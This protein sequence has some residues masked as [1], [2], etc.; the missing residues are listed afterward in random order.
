MTTT[1]VD[2]IFEMKIDGTWVDITA[3]I[4]LNS[5]DSGGGINIERGIPN[6]GNQ[7]EPTQLDFVLNNRH[8]DY[9]P[10]N[11][12]SV[13]YGKLGRNQPVRVGLSRRRDEFDR[14][15]ADSWG[16]L[17]DRVTPELETV[18][19]ERWNI[20]GTSSAFD[21]TP[22]AGTIQAATG[23]RGATFGTYGDVEILAR[24]KVSN[25]TSEFGVVM[26][27]KSTIESTDPGDFES[28]LGSWLPFG[29]TSTLVV[30]TA[31]FH[32]GAHSALLTVAG[33]PAQAYSRPDGVPVIPGRSYRTRIWVRCSATRN[34]QPVID[35]LDSG[36]GYISSTVDNIAVTADTWTVMEVTGNAPDNAAF[37]QYG[38]TLDS[39]PANGTLLF[40]DDLELLDL[41]DIEYFT[42]YITP[43]TPDLLRLGKVTGGVAEA[44]SLSQ[45][46]NVVADTFYWFKAQMS[47][48]RRRVKFWA[49]GDD[50][51]RLWNWRTYETAAA[52][53]DQT[54]Q[55][56][57]EVG[58]FCKDGTALVTFSEV[59]INQWRAHAEIQQLPQRWDLSRQDR[60]VPVAARGILQ[61]LGQGRKSLDSAVTLHLQEYTTSRMWI[62]LETIDSGSTTA[63]NRVAGGTDALVRGLTAATPEQ[64]GTLALP[65]VSGYVT[66]DDENSFLIARARPGAAA[67]V[68]SILVFWKL[69]S[70]PASDV[71]LYQVESSGTGRR[72][73]VYL[74]TDLNMRIEVRSDINVLLDQAFGLSYFGTEHPQGCWLAA[75]LYILQNGGNVDYAWNYH[76]PGGAN[77]YTANGSFAGTAGIFREIRFNSTAAIVTAGNLSITQIF[78]YPGDLP[79]VTADFA[80]AAYAYIGEEAVTRYLRLTLNAGIKSTTTGFTGDS[81]PMGAQV[82]AKLLDNLQ[83]CAEIDDSILMEERDDD[84]LN[85]RTR[86]S[87]WNQ[88]PLELDIDAGHL[89][90][91]LDPT[92]DDQRT[93]NDITVKRVNGSFATSVQTEGPLNVNAPEDDPDGVGTYDEG[94]EMNFHVDTQLQ[95]AA[96]WRRSRGTIDDPRYPGVHADFTATA[97]QA[98]PALAASL[99]AKDSGD[100]LSILNVEVGYNPTEQI[101]Q[102]YREQL[103]QYDFDLTF[104]T[105]PGKVY[106]VGVMNKTTRLA[107]RYLFLDAD[108]DAGTDARMVT[109]VVGRP[110]SIPGG[111]LWVQV[112][113]DPE[114]FP[115]EIEA[116]GSRLMVRATGD[117]LNS[118][119]YFD[120]GIEDWVAHGTV[121]LYWDR[122]PGQF[123]SGI[124]SCRQTATGATTGGV[125]ADPAANAVTVAGE[126]Y[127][128]SG[129]LM[130]NVGLADVRLAVDWYQA[131]GTTF[132]STSLPTAIATTAMT[133]VHFVA[134]VTAP[135]LGVRAR[136]KTRAVLANTDILWAD[137][138]RLMPV[139]SYE[140]SPQ[141]LSVDLVPT[142]GVDNLTLPN[143]SPIKLVAPWQ[144]AY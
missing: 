9:S 97:Y 124:A 18:L 79:F 66:F 62:P 100:M 54:V 80:R 7:A 6:E 105:A 39:N 2:P 42:A 57:G 139:T 11:P 3:D 109:A 81:K 104:I 33:S 5:A 101:I 69:P 142:N 63:G 121:T 35:W 120:E 50:E 59:E 55:A 37:A 88:I 15:E 75:N 43:G 132:I 87:L 12:Y 134:T 95:P 138:L 53:E 40:M 58:L 84:G 28:G 29:G 123:Q 130:S 70:A 61:R 102:S 52:T 32:T 19:G 23:F 127:Q 89:S 20:T 34:V 136:L 92:R 117:V 133:W 93:R 140:A 90:P 128:V 46:S 67:G 25:L 94:P 106:R 36:G 72:Y 38:P 114:S 16:R 112:A 49:D 137:D 107:T 91:P 56:F 60:W 68:W 103:D 115:F 24:V 110:T 118:N 86:E 48:I 74:Q 64:T 76:R 73:L 116:A 83:Q 30:S 14:T 4:R 8:G 78:H 65:G 129:W 119:P 26:R 135:A 99:L 122:Y 131:N 13:N 141:T 85:M 71:L 125:V 51:P 47:G 10:E 1:P 44:V 21:V 77:F 111:G 143:G 45:S 126:D 31:Q 17:P 27:L 108:F 82:P 41:T 98:D 113:D 96:N 22:G 144:V